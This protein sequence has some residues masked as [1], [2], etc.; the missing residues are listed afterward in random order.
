[1]S[2]KKFHVTYWNPGD[3]A[4]VTKVM[5]KVLPRKTIKKVVL[6]MSRPGK[7]PVDVYDVLKEIPNEIVEV[8]SDKVWMVRYKTGGFFKPKQVQFFLSLIHI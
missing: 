6:K 2:K 3:D 8:E 7:T 4:L 5:A 1:M